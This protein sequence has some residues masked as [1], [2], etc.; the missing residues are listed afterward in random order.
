MLHFVWGSTLNFSWFLR[1]FFCS[2]LHLTTKALREGLARTYQLNNCIFSLSES[3][4]SSPQK[5]LRLF[6]RESRFSF[7]HILTTLCLW[8]TENIDLQMSRRCICYLRQGF[9]LIKYILARDQLFL[10][11]K[12][13][14][15]RASFVLV[16]SNLSQNGRESWA[17]WQEPSKQQPLHDMA[18]HVWTC[19]SSLKHHFVASGLW[20]FEW[21]I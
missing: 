15:Q 6:S 5:L 9:S 4:P 13:W 8:P 11:D 17:V 2:Q 3:P 10:E 19:A 14:S 7:Y 18:K 16:V 21:I 1:I 12:L 20:N